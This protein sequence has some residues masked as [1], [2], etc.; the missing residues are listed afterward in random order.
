M[1][2]GSREKGSDRGRMGQEKELRKDVGLAVISLL[3]S[4]R[5]YLA[6]GCPWVGSR[7]HKLLAKLLRAILQE[8]G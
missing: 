5:K 2:E 1:G 8:G 4:V 7:G 3:Y 6:V